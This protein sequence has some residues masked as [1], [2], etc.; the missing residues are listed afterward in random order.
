MSRCI[1]KTILS[2]VAIIAFNSAGYANA[3]DNCDLKEIQKTDKSVKDLICDNELGSFYLKYSP[4][5]RRIWVE[6][7]RNGLKLVWVS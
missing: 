1:T 4:V 3:A 7:R 5:K 6:S 2:L